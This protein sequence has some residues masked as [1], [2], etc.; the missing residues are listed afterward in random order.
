MCVIAGDTTM[1]VRIVPLS[2]IPGELPLWAALISAE[3][4]PGNPEPLP[5]NRIDRENGTH[6]IRSYMSHTLEFTVSSCWC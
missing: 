5:G 6:I 1:C 2:H 4:R 3:M